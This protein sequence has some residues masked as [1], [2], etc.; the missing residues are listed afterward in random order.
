MRQERLERGRK[1][2]AGALE[3]LRDERL[4]DSHELKTT[5]PVKEVEAAVLAALKA[6]P[7]FAVTGNDSPMPDTFV[8]DATQEMSTAL[9]TSAGRRR[10]IIVGAQTKD[11]ETQILFKVLEYKVEAVNK[12]SIGALI[13]A[14]VAVNYIPIDAS[15]TNRMTDR[16][17][18]Q[19]KEGV[20]IVTERIQAAINKMEK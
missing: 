6:Q 5:R 12:F 1:V 9:A 14:P 4:F 15:Q 11:D 7:S 19:L 20:T 17:Q 3:H 18:A 10:S 13:H 16:L 8:I 2:F